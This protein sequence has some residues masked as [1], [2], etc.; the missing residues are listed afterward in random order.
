M[1]YLL[2][3]G[4]V[5]SVCYPRV[6]CCVGIDYVIVAGMVQVEPM[7]SSCWRSVLEAEG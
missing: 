2:V 7:S 1:R 3:P 4:A 5:L 6:W